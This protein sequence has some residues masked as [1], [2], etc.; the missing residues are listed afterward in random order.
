MPS[1]NPPLEP[2]PVLFIPLPSNIFSNKF[3]PNIPNK[4]PRNPHFYPFALFCIVSLTPFN[5]KPESSRDL[6]IFIMSFISSFDIICVVDPDPK[7]F[8]CIPAS[9]VD[10]AAVNPNGIKTL[11]DNG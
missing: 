2:Y 8:L 6:T 11:L 3:A 9:A 5:D 1:G 4:I 7:I 10:V